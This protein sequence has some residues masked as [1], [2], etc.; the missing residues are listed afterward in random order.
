MGACLEEFLQSVR[1]ELP[2]ASIPDVLP[3]LRGEAFGNGTSDSAPAADAPSAEHRY[4][5]GYEPGRNLA[6]A[7]ALKPNPA[8]WWISLPSVRGE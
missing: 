8:E 7:L 2:H 4:R 6:P 3:L 1:A 5:A